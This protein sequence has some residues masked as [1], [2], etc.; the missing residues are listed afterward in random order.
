MIIVGGGVS[1]LAAYNQLLLNGITDV[2]LF[3]GSDHLGGRVK[4]FNF[5]QIVNNTY[6]KLMTLIYSFLKKN[7]RNLN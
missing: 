2:L 3:E 7:N 1:G 4:T 6:G 5:N